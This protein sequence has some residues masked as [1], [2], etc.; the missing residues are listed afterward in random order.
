MIVLDTNVLSALMQRRPD[1]QVIGW[2]DGL[3]AESIWLTTITVF[4]IRF[5]IEILAAGRK[6]QRIEMA[7]ENSL[8]EDFG[9]RVLA[10]DQPAAHAAA[11]IAANLRSLGRRPEIRDV[12]IAGIVSTRKA[13]LAT[14]NTKLFESTGLPLVDPWGK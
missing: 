13:T 11:R 6:R 3:P 12:E 10:F 4:E 2:L 5:G 8:V 1:P 9:Q 7:F 14:R